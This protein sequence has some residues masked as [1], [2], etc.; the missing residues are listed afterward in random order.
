MNINIP[1]PL[2]IVLCTSVLISGC[3][4]DGTDSSKNSQIRTGSEAVIQGTNTQVNISNPHNHTTGLSGNQPAA[5]LVTNNDNKG[6]QAGTDAKNIGTANRNMPTSFN[7]S[8]SSINTA[9]RALGSTGIPTYNTHTV[10]VGSSTTVV[11]THG[12]GNSAD[13]VPLPYVQVSAVSNELT[14]HKNAVVPGIPYQAP[15]HNHIAPYPMAFE[16][17]HEKAVMHTTVW[18]AVTNRS[19]TLQHLK[20]L[21]KSSVLNYGSGYL[22]RGTFATRYIQGAPLEPHS[23][24][25]AHTV[26][27]LSDRYDRNK[28]DGFKHIDMSLNANGNHGGDGGEDNI[29]IYIVDSSNPYQNF[30]CFF[31]EHDAVDKHEALK[32]ATVRNDIPIPRWAVPSQ[33]GDRALA[34]YDVSTGIWRSYYRVYTDAKRRDGTPCW[35]FESAGYLRFD[36]ALMKVKNNNFWLSHLSGT[37]TVT[38]VAT[39]LLQVGFAEIKAAEIKHALSF[40]FPNYRH[41]AY[42]PAKLNDGTE[43]GEGIPETNDNRHLPVAG[44]MFTFPAAFN[45]D[46]WARDNHVGKEMIAVMKAVQKYGGFVADKNHYNIAL[47]MESVLSYEQNPYH[48]DPELKAAVGRL[49]EDIRKFPWGKTVWI[50]KGYSGHLTDANGEQR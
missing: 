7:S 28:P 9:S 19:L 50:Q 1:N 2:L 22:G 32:A 49:S 15:T 25:M 12:T 39:E 40:T 10:P 38:G 44:Q 45:I 36:P 37:S 13:F 26:G 14:A 17:D 47:N 18:R 4:R 8:V 27:A 41:K 33:G 46:A 30:Q 5:N 43:S 34:I 31:S 3:K 20:N 23:L 29:P 35:Y 21:E 11:S 24:A 16:N 6:F 48:T 42:F